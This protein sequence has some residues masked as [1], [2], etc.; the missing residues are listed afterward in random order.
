MMKV[1]RFFICFMISFAIVSLSG[2]G[3][4][5]NDISDSLAATTFIATILIITIFLSVLV[6]IYLNLRNKINSLTKRI[7]EL[8]QN[9]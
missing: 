3:N 6:E 2:Y 4:L 8:E 1:V 9:K 5:M 7:E